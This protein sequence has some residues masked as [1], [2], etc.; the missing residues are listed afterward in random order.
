MATTIQTTKPR[1]M[2]RKLLWKVLRSRA[3]RMTQ[4]EL[5]QD[6]W[7]IAPHQDDEVLSC[8]GTIMQKLARGATVRVVFVTDGTSSHQHP[9]GKEA[10]RKERREE[11]VSACRVLGIPATNLVFLDLPDGRLSENISQAT[12]ALA[13]ILRDHSV[14][15]I[16]MPFRHDEHPDH[17]ATHMITAAALDTLNSP[18]VRWEYG[19]WLWNHWP[20]VPLRKGSL[21]SK[22]G[23]AKYSLELSMHL[24]RH[25]RYSVDVS[26]YVKEKRQALYEHRSQLKQRAGS[27]AWM[28]LEDVSDGEWLDCFFRSHEFFCRKQT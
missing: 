25:F 11:A 2:L 12:Q 24:L 4:F 15:Q 23:F 16:F 5:E 21:Q 3:D 17:I 22:L 7:V 27:Q 18:F 1:K 28:T 9:N 13:N 14:E 8:G 19:T 10:L 6:A 26:E 20:W